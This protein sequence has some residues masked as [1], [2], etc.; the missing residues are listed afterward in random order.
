M[1]STSAIDT[2]LTATVGADSLPVTVTGFQSV[3]GLSQLYSFQ[4]QFLSDRRFTVADLVGKPAA[5]TLQSKVS[6]EAEYRTRH[7]QGLIK[8]F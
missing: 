5:V 3:E 8:R 7:F 6:V 1:T 2:Q 4:L